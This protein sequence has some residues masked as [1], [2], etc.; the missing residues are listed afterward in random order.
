MGSTCCTS[1]CETVQSHANPA[2]RRILWIALTANTLMFLIE[3]AAGAVSGS[4]SLQADALDFLGDA[5]NYAISLGVTGMALAWRART[6]MIKGFTIF[7][8][9]LGVLI[10]AI[11][12]LFAGGQPEPWMMSGIGALALFVNVTVALMLYRFRSGDANM[13]SVW[14]CSRNDAINNLLVIAAGFAVLLTGSGLPDIIAAF[15]IAF[16][17][18][19]GGLEVIK[20]ARR[21][22]S[23]ADA[24]T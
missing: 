10:S 7:T 21:E 1:S 22:L 8:F 5:A 2:W 20:Q 16:L 3:I 11:W 6:A 14:I 24:A 15:I 12:G 17:G 18:L 9:A 13:R 19:Q 23:G 4:R